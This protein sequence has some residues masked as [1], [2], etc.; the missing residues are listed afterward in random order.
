MEGVANPNL[1]RFHFDG[2]VLSDL[3]C[4]KCQLSLLSVFCDFS[5]VLCVYLVLHG[6]RV[7]VFLDTRFLASKRA[8]FLPSR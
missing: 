4:T 8:R 6:G 1:T 2:H 3:E 7:F 5:M